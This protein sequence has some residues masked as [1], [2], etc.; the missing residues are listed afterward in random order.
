MH[1]L[2]ATVHRPG[3][4]ILRLLQGAGLKCRASLWVRLTVM[5]LLNS[6]HT[7]MRGR[8]TRPACLQLLQTARVDQYQHSFQQRWAGNAV[9]EPAHTQH[10]LLSIIKAG[11]WLAIEAAA[12]L[13]VPPKHAYKILRRHL[14]IILLSLVCFLFW[15][16]WEVCQ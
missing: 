9:Q 5:G 14:Q 15:V 1:V 11:V 3:M 8:V 4:L 7:C 10:G 6:K 13:Q 2:N 16:I 12:V